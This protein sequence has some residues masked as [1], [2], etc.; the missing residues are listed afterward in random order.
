MAAY[1]RLNR[2]VPG[3]CNTICDLTGFRVKMSEIR[4]QWDGTRVIAKAWSRRNPQ[5]FAPTIIPTKV[6][7]HSR[8]ET[9]FPEVNYQQPYTIV[10]DSDGVA[11]QV[12]NEVI[13]SDGG[14]YPV[15]DYVMDSE[16]KMWRIFKSDL[17]W[18]IV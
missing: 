14:V 13:A 11:Y 7:E 17:E 8:F 4:E 1:R 6:W 10:Y 3:T 9:P 5:D 12:T 18:N 16:G 15:D 2:F